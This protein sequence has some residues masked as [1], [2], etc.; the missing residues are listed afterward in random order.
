MDLSWK[1]ADTLGQR[2]RLVIWETLAAR[3][4]ADCYPREATSTQLA[5]LRSR[6]P[7]SAI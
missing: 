1:L 5:A 4:T 7:R 6:L 2:P 3:D